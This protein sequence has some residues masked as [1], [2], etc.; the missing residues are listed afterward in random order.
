MSMSQGANT[1]KLP[2][3][4]IEPGLQDLKE[5]TLLYHCK[6]RFQPSDSSSVLYT[7]PYYIFPCVELIRPR[8]YSEPRYNSKTFSSLSQGPTYRPQMSQGREK[9]QM[10][11]IGIEPGLKDLNVNTLP[12]H[13]ESR[14]L[15][16]PKTCTL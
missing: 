9:S 11:K 3:V 7:F 4:G 12:R 14:L 8:I 2:K 10:P 15:V 13:C 5:N 6:S 16:W 1:S